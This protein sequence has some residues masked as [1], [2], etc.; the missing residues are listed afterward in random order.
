MGEE[1]VQGRVQNTH[2]LPYRWLTQPSPQEELR[3][4]LAHH[5]VVGVGSGVQEHEEVLGRM[6]DGQTDH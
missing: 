2:L 1:G 5:Q 4:E 6:E 3:K